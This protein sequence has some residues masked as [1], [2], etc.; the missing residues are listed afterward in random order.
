MKNTI[1]LFC[2]SLFFSCSGQKFIKTVKNKKNLQEIVDFKGYLLKEN[3]M[4]D[5]KESKIVGNVY[6]SRVKRF[7]TKYNIT[8][9]HIQTCN[10]Y[11]YVTP[12]SH[13]TNCGNLI[14]LYFGIPLTTSEHV[15]IFDYSKED[16]ILKEG[17]SE[18]KY[19]ISDKIFVF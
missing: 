9:I 8:A 5:F 10:K 19:K 15:L 7:L 18:K 14:E 2:C 11:N 16:L 6:D 17:L 1:L 3:I 12:E 13:F 4:E